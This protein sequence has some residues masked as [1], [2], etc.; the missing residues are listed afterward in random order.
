MTSSEPIPSYTLNDG[1]ELPAI[2]LGTYALWGAEGVASIVSGLQ[3]GYRLIDSAVNYENEGAVGEAV[4]RSGVPA[5][6][7]ILTSKLPGR[8][9]A[10]A[11]A[12]TCVHE[13]L[14]RLRTDQIGLYLIHWPNPLEDRYVE[15]WQALI[16][17]QKEGVL[18]SIGVSN[19]L[20]EHLSRIIGETGVTPAVNQVELHPHFPQQRQR[21]VNAELGIRTESWSPIGRA[22]GV[23][24]E[25]AV[26]AVADA[27]ERTPVQVVLR[28]QVQLGS[29]PVPKASSAD[30][31]QE[32]LDVFD[33]T[34][35]D[36]QMASI[37]G[38]GR[39][40]GRLFDADPA[41]H[42]EF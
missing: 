23:V 41:I 17:L 25:P 31:Q 15:A 30:R 13:S 8:H 5:D 14:Y 32:N 37:S 6:E 16:D 38:L 29:I 27:V 7:I 9:H 22:G 21:T 2:G 42:Q 1:H 20:P 26:L 11:K 33:F 28:W 19:F 39:G 24:H 36:A 34:L 40:D 4:Q 3:A 10:Y 18:R 12:R 35:D